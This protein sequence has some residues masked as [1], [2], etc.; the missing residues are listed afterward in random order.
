MPSLANVIIFLLALRHSL[1]TALSFKTD[2]NSLMVRESVYRRGLVPN[3]AQNAFLA[4]TTADISAV[5]QTEVRRVW[6]DGTARTAQCSVFLKTTTNWEITPV[7][8]K[9]TWS[10]W[11][12]FVDST[13][14]VL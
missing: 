9:A 3:A 11:T 10:A 7:T 2:A 14:T 6:K 12:A 13:R 1:K 4:M 8:T 5:R